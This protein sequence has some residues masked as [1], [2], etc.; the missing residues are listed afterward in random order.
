MIKNDT[1]N[2]LQWYD[3]VQVVYNKQKNPLQVCFYQNN[4]S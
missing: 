1:P 3:E 4:D 2:V